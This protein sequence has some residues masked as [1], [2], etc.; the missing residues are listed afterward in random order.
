MWGGIILE[1]VL[2][3]YYLL[4]HHLGDTLSLTCSLILHAGRGNSSIVH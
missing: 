3:N 1:N 2:V 4:K